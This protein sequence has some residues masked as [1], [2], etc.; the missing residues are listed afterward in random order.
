[1]ARFLDPAG[2]VKRDPFVLGSREESSSTKA[3]KVGPTQLSDAQLR[4]ASVL[5]HIDNLLDAQAEGG[6]SLEQAGDLSCDL[7]DNIKRL[8]ALF[9]M[10]ENKDLVMRDL[11]IATQPPTRAVV[12]FMEGMSDKTTIN[13]AIMQPLMLFAHLDHHLSGEG[14][15]G[16]TTFSV[17]TV[18]ERL[19]I[20]NQATKKYDLKSVAE[21]LLYGDSV[22]LFEGSRVAIG[23]ETKG[24]PVRSVT[25][26]QVERVIQGPQ[27]A[28]VESF[29]FNVALVRKRLK[30]PR[31][32]TEMLTVGDLSQTY[33]AMMFLDGIANPELVNE[34]R[35]RIKA[36]KT[37]VVGSA[38]VLEQFIEDSPSALLPGMLT[39]ERPDR[40]VAY[41]SEGNVCLCVDGTPFVLVCPIT[42]WGLLQ[43]SEDYYLRAP[44]GTLIRFLRLT[45]LGIALL[46]PAFYI[47]IV[48]YHP[49]MIPTELMLFAASSRESVPMPAVVE[50]LLMDM[51]FELIREAGIRIPNVIGPTIGLV[52]SLILGQAAVEA[53]LVSP[54]LI[55]IVAITGLASFAVPHYMSGFGIRSLR[56]LFVLAATLLGFYGLAA[57]LFILIVHM[58]SMRSFGVPY[59]APGAPARGGLTDMLVR[60]PMFDMELRPAYTSPL[61][62]RRQKEIVRTWDPHVPPSGEGDDP[63]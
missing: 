10:P 25:T 6:D 9:R 19:I 40:A 45:A 13:T 28:F 20:G 31:M 56:F 54:L 61:D 5:T 41:L 55:L 1:M 32:V 52:A 29:R 15:N 63:H 47:A 49:E 42:F 39:T 53:K 2:G 38:G 37:D 35:R 24:F 50:L 62:D 8:K 46:V 14:E 57:A 36:V 27:D 11:V 4:T 44:F 23:V 7:D 18:I 21:S 43:T 16:P 48:N 34:V 17:D 3:E 30:D 12:F 60:P 51:A 58:A 59:L 26:P 33:V 22:L